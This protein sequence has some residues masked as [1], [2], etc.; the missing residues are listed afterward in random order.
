M[1]HGEGK[2]LYGDGGVG[3]PG[4]GGR[5]RPDDGHGARTLSG[6]RGGR[7]P[8]GGRWRAGADG[9]DVGER[10]GGACRGRRRGGGALDNGG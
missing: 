5:M 9:L 1:H 6:G 7:D 8:G 2:P 4:R 10:R 3:G